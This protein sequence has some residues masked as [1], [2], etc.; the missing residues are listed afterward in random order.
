MRETPTVEEIL[1]ANAMQP[2][3][4]ATTAYWVPAPE[5]ITALAAIENAEARAAMDTTM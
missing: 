5:R 1:A 4:I 2:E 3:V